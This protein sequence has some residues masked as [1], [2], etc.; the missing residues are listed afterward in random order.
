MKYMKYILIFSLFFNFLL[1][2][3]LFNKNNIYEAD[4]TDLVENFSGEIG[5]ALANNYLEGDLQAHFKCNVLDSLES[6]FVNFDPEE[7]E[8]VDKFNVLTDD[9]SYLIKRM[10][11]ESTNKGIADREFSL[12]LAKHFVLYSI[13]NYI[14]RTYIYFN[15]VYVHAYSKKDTISLG[16]EYVAHIPYI[17]VITNYKPTLIVNG[18]TVPTDGD[19]DV[20]YFK[21][22]A[23]K[24]GLIKNEGSITLFVGGRHMKL[25]FEFEYYVK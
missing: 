6:Y 7:D 21:E 17:G 14:N 23:N 18:D 12:K 3:L 20:Y 13:E 24:K 4:Y 9:Q 10:L 5:Y 25:P 2:Y 1:L 15:A 19:S 16:E 8:F 11:K 22:K